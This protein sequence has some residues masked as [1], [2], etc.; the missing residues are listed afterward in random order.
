MIN[1]IQEYVGYLHNVK[2]ISYNTEISYER[3]LKKAADYFHEMD[4]N[5]V[6]DVTETNLNSYVLHLEQN[7]MS[8]ATVS[9]NI[10]SLRS[11][12]RYLVKEKKLE[13]DPTE[14]LKPPKV[15]K[16]AP[17]VLSQ[18][19]IALL[20]KQPNMNTAKG[21]RD[22][23]MLELLYATGIRVSEL[24]HLRKGDVNLQMGYITCSDQ[25]RER[26]IPFS[27]GVGRI[28][29]SY[30]EDAREKLLKGRQ[31]ECFFM[32]CQGNPMSRQGFWKVLK[33]YARSAGIK[34]DITPHTLRHSF[35]M[36]QLKSGTDLKSIQEMLGHAD[37]ST[38]QIYVDSLKE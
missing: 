21:V 38:T 8:P 25:G 17:E 10:A 3:D 16:K 15:D 30:L 35:A 23:A 34:K 29:G 12:F 32:N 7:H 13:D 28:L 9:R 20:L 24:I 27:A 33:G 6:R 36:H 1:A 5:D 19:E 26:S 14:K 31:C 37:L 22:R 18:E 4:I 11:F 2:K